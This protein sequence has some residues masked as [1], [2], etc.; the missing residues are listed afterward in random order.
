MS[1]DRDIQT[2]DFPVIEESKTVNWLDQNKGLLFAGASLL[3]AGIGVFSFL[4][5]PTSIPTRGDTVGELLETMKTLDIDPKDLDSTKIKQYFKNT[6]DVIDPE[7]FKW[8][9]FWA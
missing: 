1:Q 8:A 6:A 7:L 2:E 4:R 3:G 9:L 5:N